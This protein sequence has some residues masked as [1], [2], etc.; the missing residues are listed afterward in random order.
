MKNIRVGLAIQQSIAGAFEENLSR[1]LGAV[2]RAGAEQAD[3]I[4]FPEMNLTGYL[5]GSRIQ[6]IARPLDSSWIDSLSQASNCH[7]LTILAGLVELADDDRIYA[8]QLVISPHAPLSYYRKIHLAPYET[9]YFSPG[10]RVQMFEQQGLRFGIQLCYDAHFP[11]LSTA[12]ALKGADVIFFPHASPRGS[13]QEKYRSWMRHLT[14][15]GFDNGVFVAAVN[16][17]GDNQGGLEFP[18]LALVIGPDGYPVSECVEPAET[19]HWVN[20]DMSAIDRV[21]DH[22]MRYFL[23]NRRTDLFQ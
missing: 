7:N 23:P 10:S 17:T 20:M 6:S 12:M 15:R 3:F 22:K 8:T 9:P 5:A 16:Q 18:G 4:V 19:I 2:A 1:S 11:E 21:R 14:A 13:S